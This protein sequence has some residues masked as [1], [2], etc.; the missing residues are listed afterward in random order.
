MLS[1][2]G[3]EISARE[4]NYNN[5]LCVYDMKMLLYASVFDFLFGDDKKYVLRRF[6]IYVVNVGS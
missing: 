2:W 5:T 3:H 4:F 6:N 1:M